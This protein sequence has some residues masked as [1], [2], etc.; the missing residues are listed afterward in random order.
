MNCKPK[1]IELEAL[2]RRTLKGRTSRVI[3][4][5]GDTTRYELYIIPFAN[6]KLRQSG[7]DTTHSLLVITGPRA[8]QSAYP[9]SHTF[10]PNEGYM[11]SHLRVDEHVAGILC[12]FWIELNDVVRSLAQHTDT[13]IVED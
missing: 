10:D 4:E 3:L 1:N 8:C 9:F 2:A 7:T 6:P 12:Q 13:N 5:P 11:Q